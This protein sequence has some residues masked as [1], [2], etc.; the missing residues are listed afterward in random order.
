MFHKLIDDFQWRCGENSKD[1]HRYQ[2][3]KRLSNFLKPKAFHTAR[4]LTHSSHFKP[5]N[6]LSA[7]MH[8][9]RAKPNIAQYVEDENNPIRA[10]FCRSETKRMVGRFEFVCYCTII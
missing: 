2:S 6:C 3:F 1:F 8:R 10:V 4:L 5:E 7:T 9:S